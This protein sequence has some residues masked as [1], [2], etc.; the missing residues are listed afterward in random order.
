[1]RFETYEPFIYLIFQ[2]FSGH[3]KPQITGTA[4]TESADAGGT[5]VLISSADPTDISVGNCCGYKNICLL[6]ALIVLR[7]FLCASN[8]FCEHRNVKNH[9]ISNG[10]FN[11]NLLA[12]EFGI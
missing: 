12:L 4:D 1:M 11:I 8:I 2:F 3:G 10:Q 7:K 6:R 5:T 9:N